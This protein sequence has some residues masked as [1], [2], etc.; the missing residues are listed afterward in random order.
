MERE[1]VGPPPAVD[2]SHGEHS[3][4][5]L[6]AGTSARRRMLIWVGYAYLILLGG[7]FW[8]LV[9]SRSGRAEQWVLPWMI[10]TFVLL[11]IPW[12]WLSAW[13][14]RRAGREH[15]AGYTTLP[16]ERGRG[17]WVLDDRTGEVLSEPSKPRTTT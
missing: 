11:F 1:P 17:F 6:L 5:T 8:V 12:L 4:P 7:L 16:F 3:V 2:Q 14:L 10:G 9:G 15:R 13:V